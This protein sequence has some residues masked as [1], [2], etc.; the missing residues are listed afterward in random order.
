MSDFPA[1]FTIDYSK[2]KFLTVSTDEDGVCV[3]RMNDPEHGGLKGAPKFPNPPIF[4]FLWQNAFRTGA[5]EGQE[6]RR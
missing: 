1:P 5:P 4:R 3:L 2:Y 6:A